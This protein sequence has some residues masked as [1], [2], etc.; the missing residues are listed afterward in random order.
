M[1]AAGRK[2]IHI[3]MDCFFSAIEEREHPELRGKPHAV[4]GASERRGVLATCNY[5]AREFGLHS[6]MPTRTAL[7]LCPDLVLQPGNMSL[8]KAVSAS[9]FEILGRYTEIIEPLSLDEAFLDVTGLGS[10]T[11]IAEDIR[12]TIREE[13]QLTASAGIA[14]NKFLAKIAS[15]WNKPDG[16]FVIT[17]GRID[18]FVRQ[19]PIEKIYGVGKVTAEKMHE[20]GIRTCAD[21]QGYDK[22]SLNEHFGSFGERLYDYA[23]GI[24]HRPVSTSRIRKSVSTETTFS[25]DLESLEDCITYLPDLISRLEQR[26]ARLSDRQ[27]HALFIK[28]K[29][30]DFRTT[31]VQAVSTHIDE[32]L[33]LTLLRK[34]WSRSERAVR[35]LGIGV[36]LAT[37]EGNTSQIELDLD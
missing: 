13:Q 21:L 5:K 19:L 18:A 9:I 17:P 27:I 37:E 6:A 26:L 23:R 32:Q 4:G 16:Q 10:A 11:L 7:R 28:L 2:I 35:L 31:T 12:R 14:P 22:N 20:L 29:F 8:Y 15:D 25:S 36:Q 33:A 30:S 1:S 34:G 24:D 3:D